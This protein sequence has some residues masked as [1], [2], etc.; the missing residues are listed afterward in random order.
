MSLELRLRVWCGRRGNDWVSHILVSQRLLFVVIGTSAHFHLLY[1]VVLPVCPHNCH[2]MSNSYDFNSNQLLHS[3]LDAK[4]I[5]LGFRMSVYSISVCPTWAR[6]WPYIVL[7]SSALR[8]FGFALL[9]C[10]F[11]LLTCGLL[12]WH[13]ACFAVLCRFPCLADIWLGFA[14]LQLCFAL[15]SFADM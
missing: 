4:M 10:G 2:T 7:L 14:D 15:L 9:T 11:A 13:A 8:S 3:R 5:D 1:R 6:N 12:C